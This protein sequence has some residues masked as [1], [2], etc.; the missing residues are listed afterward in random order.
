MSFINPYTYHLHV[1]MAQYLRN[2]W[3]SQHIVEF[4]SPS[5]HQPRAVFFEMILALGVTAAWWS[6]TKRRYTELI[7]IGVWAHAGLLA[8]R[9]I[10]IFVIVAAPIIAA[11]IQHALEQAAEANVAGWVRTVAMRFNG[12]VAQTA[13]K[14][15]VS[16]WHLVSA[17]GFAMMAAVFFAPNPPEKFRAEFDPKRYPEAALAAIAAGFRVADFYARR[18]GRLPD[19]ESV[20]QGKGLRRWPER[21]LRQRL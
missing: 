12:M 7:L 10:P 9:N 8:S 21:F 14:E 1:H 5:F 11:A 13:E 20:P 3:N 2:P 4:L 16:R 6:F 17:A 19:L 15:A 18:V